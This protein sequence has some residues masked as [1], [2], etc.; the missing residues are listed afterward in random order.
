[1]RR[2][3]GRRGFGLL[4]LVVVLAIVGILLVIVVPGV[5]RWRSN[6][7]VRDAADKLAAH[8]R[9]AQATAQNLPAAQGG[10]FIPPVP[11]GEGEGG[12]EFE[13]SSEGISSDVVGSIS[14]SE[15]TTNNCYR[16]MSNRQGAWVVLQKETLPDTVTVNVNSLYAVDRFTGTEAVAIVSFGAGRALAFSSNGQT[17]SNNSLSVTLT[18]GSVTKTVTVT[19]AGTVQVQ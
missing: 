15:R 1:M 16:L 10:P 2:C 19:R 8:L 5:A 7:A 11:G 6:Q 13:A 17:T 14:A 3:R 4:E 9:T 18:N 12:A